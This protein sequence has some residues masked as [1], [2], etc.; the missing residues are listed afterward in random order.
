MHLT[1]ALLTKRP[2]SC[3]YTRETGY[4][5]PPHQQIKENGITP[6]SAHALL[7]VPAQ[8]DLIFG[9]VLLCVCSCRKGQ[10][11]GIICLWDTHEKCCIPTKFGL[12]AGWNISHDIPRLVTAQS[13]AKYLCLWKAAPSQVTHPAVLHQWLLSHLGCLT[14]PSKEQWLLSIPLAFLGRPYLLAAAFCLKALCTS[15]MSART[16][17]EMALTGEQT[18]ARGFCVTWQ[19]HCCSGT[20]ALHHPQLRFQYHNPSQKP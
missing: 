10:L 18:F 19:H 15:H 2:Q 12:L 6:G 16:V 20:W 14:E 17:F 4:L 11:S 7:F 13:S 1:L 8:L 3:W 9:W 5:L